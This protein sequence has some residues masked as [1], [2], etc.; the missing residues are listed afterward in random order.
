MLR[1]LEEAYKIQQLQGVSLSPEQMF[2]LA[3]LGGAKALSMEGKVGNFAVG[4]EA[5]FL[6]L[7]PQATPLMK[8]R[9]EFCQDWRELLFVLQVLGDDRAIWQTNVMG[10]PTSLQ[11]S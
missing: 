2:Y 5:D 1:T 7:D 4:N 9:T 11:T 6:I 3:T 8:F 10:K